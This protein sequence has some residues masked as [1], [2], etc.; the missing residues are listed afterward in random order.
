MKKITKAVIPAAGLGTRMLPIA[1]AVPKE[2]LPIV[3]RPALSYLVNE[4]AD[5]GIT[6]ILIITNRGKEAF[7]DYFDYSPEYDKYLRQSG[8][9]TEA[10]SLREIADRANIYFLRQKEARGLGH[11]VRRA[12]SFTGDDPFMV[13]YGDDVIVSET[14]VCAQL[15]KVY[16]KYGLPC[17][18]VKEVSLELVLKY[19][20]L[21]AR[22]VG[23]DIYRVCT[24][25]EKPRPEQIMTRFAI[26]GRVLLVPEIYDILDSISYGTGGELQLTDA[27]KNLA[28]SRP[29]GGM[30]ALDFEGRRYD[31]G[32]KLGFLE[33][34]VEQAVHH[35]EIGEAFKQFLR[36]FA[37]KL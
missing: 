6:D 12:K 36:E 15:M 14:P 37:A 1:H 2:L 4:A 19:C 10:D 29:D 33:A 3:D 31:M 26:L 35:P 21:D 20:T 11:A 18:G 17:A 7:Q 24:M 9:I 22:P 28:E 27:M 23:D 34:N 30:T 16:E 13:L 25:I 5:S 8:K 32:S